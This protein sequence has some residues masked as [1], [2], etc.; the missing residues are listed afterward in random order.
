M[1][2]STRR[3]SIRLPIQMKVKIT[4]DSY[5]TQQVI[6]KDFSDGGIFVEDAE[7]AKLDVGSLVTVQAD[8]GIDDAPVISARIAWTN[9]V[10]AGIEYLLD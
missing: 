5:C 4:S 10:G 3:T 8:E 7:L 2:Q 1:T 9:K 6:T